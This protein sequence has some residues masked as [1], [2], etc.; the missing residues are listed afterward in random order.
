MIY[1]LQMFFC[2][3]MYL[4]MGSGSRGSGITRQNQ[5]YSWMHK[6]QW[7]LVPIMV[8]S[9]WGCPYVTRKGKKI[10]MTSWRL[11]FQTLQTQWLKWL[12]VKCFDEQTA[13][14]D[15]VDV[16]IECRFEVM[17]QT[18]WRWI[19]KMLCSFNETFILSVSILRH[20]FQILKMMSQTAK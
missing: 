7:E 18:A 10:E 3:C 19:G 1:A 15:V 13:W 12:G 6:F 20:Y 14:L 11:S 17:S 5:F 4:T 16:W 8:V 9:N 2:A